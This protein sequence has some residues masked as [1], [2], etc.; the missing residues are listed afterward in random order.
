MGKRICLL[1]LVAAMPAAASEWVSEIGLGAVFTSGN[2]DQ[3]TTTF[4]ADTTRDGELWVNR[5][6]VES[7]SAVKDGV[8]SA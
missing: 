6:H 3:E 2:T 4:R 5:V 7:L 8:Q 1:F